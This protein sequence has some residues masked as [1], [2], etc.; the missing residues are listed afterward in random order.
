MTSHKKGLPLSFSATNRPRAPPVC[1]P[2]IDQTFV[3]KYKLTGIILADPHDI[4][5]SLLS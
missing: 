4:F 3:H 2:V 5:E 1:C